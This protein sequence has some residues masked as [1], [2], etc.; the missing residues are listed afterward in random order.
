VKVL[1]NSELCLRYS[2]VGFLRVTARLSKLN[3]RVENQKGKEFVVHINHI[4][5]AFKQGI[6][7]ANERERCYT[8]RRTRQPE[9]EDEQVALVI[10]RQRI[11]NRSKLCS[12]R[13]ASYETRTRNHKKAPVPY[14]TSITAASIKKAE[15]VDE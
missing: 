12:R 14:K 1:L 7:S 8:E 4:K 10:R 3:C 11:E 2:Q 13:Y 15:P 9:P 5:T 6:W